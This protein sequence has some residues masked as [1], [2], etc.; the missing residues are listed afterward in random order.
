MN[1]LRAATDAFHA[2][3]TRDPNRCV[4]LGV[5]RNLDALP[6]PSLDEVG[7]R[8]AQGRE[9][10]ALFDRVDPSALAFDDALDVD[11]ARLVV[12][13]RAF[14]DAYSMGGATRLER[15][16]TAGPDVGD[17]IYQLFIADPRPPGD[18]LADVTARVEAVPD[19]VE[20]LLGRLREPVRRWVTV[21]RERVEGLPSLFQTLS[22]WADGE[23]WADAPR[24]RAARARAEE[25]LASYSRRLSELPTTESVVVGE[26]TA[27]RIVALRGIEPPLE[28]LHRYAKDFLAETTAAIAELR[29]R[30]AAR[31]G[32]DPQ[33][34]TAAVHEHLNARFRVALPTGSLNDVLLRY[35]TERERVLAFVEE[36]ALFPIPARQDMKIVRTPDFLVPSIPAGAMVPPAPFREGVRTSIVYLTLTEELLDEHTELGIPTMM[37]HEGIPGHHLQLSTASLH[38]SI[39]RRHVDANELAEGWTTMLEDYMLDQGYAADVA[40]EVRFV[41][42]REISRI[43]ARVAIDLY[44]M[45]GDASYLE[46]GVDF[47]RSDSDPFVLAGRL[48]QAVTGFGPG[49]VEAELNWY[50]QERAYPLSYLT[51]NRLVWKLK[52]DVERRH[53]HAWSRAELD[54]RFHETFLKAGNMPVSYLRRVFEHQGLV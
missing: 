35:E 50:S 45:T 7:R 29:P 1:E 52:E 44:F 53:G 33:T 3:M 22:A 47:D 16:P 11:L 6:D 2:L 25:A 18:R 40:D 38:P 20:A 39:I 17:G 5:D 26:E 14:D 42:K 37:I 4:G 12:E 32:L 34:P 23:G 8:A 30:L 9:V 54:R 49:R 19:Y 31:H 10:L 46:V 24:L 27:R 48:L 51:G 43:G 21:D 15:F 13:A 28:E 41:A 36:R